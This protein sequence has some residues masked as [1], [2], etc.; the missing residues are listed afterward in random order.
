MSLQFTKLREGKQLAPLLN[1][2]NLSVRVGIRQVLKDMNL[3]IYKGDHIRITGP[4]GSGKSTLL[5]AIAGV[6]PAHIEKGS[7]IELNGKDITSRAPHERASLGIAYMRQTDNIFPS[8]SVGDNLRLAL[9]DD[10]A[11]RFTQTFPEW[12]NDIPLSKT[13]GLLSGGQKKKLAWGMTVL[14]QNAK[15]AL[16][17]EPKAGT[18]DSVDVEKI[19]EH[20]TV[21]EIEHS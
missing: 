7:I 5:N 2:K 4:N 9:G 14:R 6:E 3:T 13:A 11:E 18:D 20:L 21:L 17:D 1:I 16:L 10:G 12:A 8:L 15:I 19:S